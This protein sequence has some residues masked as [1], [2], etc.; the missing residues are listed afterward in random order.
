PCRYRSRGSRSSWALRAYHLR[1][2]D[3]AT[4]GG[5]KGGGPIRLLALRAYHLRQR[6]SVAHGGQTLLHLWVVEEPWSERRLAQDAAVTQLLD[7]RDVLL[8]DL[9]D[10][11]RAKLA[12]VPQVFEQRDQSAQVDQVAREPTARVHTQ[13]DVPGA[14]RRVAEVTPEQSEG[15]DELGSFVHRAGGQHACGEQPHPQPVQ[16]AGKVFGEHCQSLL[17]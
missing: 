9:P 2:G 14:G 7:D 5:G 13:R 12:S 4:Y 15:I 1:R 17:Q 6:D 8:R 11:Q 10:V 3:A 16:A